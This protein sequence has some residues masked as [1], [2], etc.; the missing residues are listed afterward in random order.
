MHLGGRLRLDTARRVWP[1]WTERHI[2]DVWAAEVSKVAAQHHD[3]GVGT[4]RDEE[5]VVGRTC[6]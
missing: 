5:D 4:E 3:E 2:H 1:G 6:R